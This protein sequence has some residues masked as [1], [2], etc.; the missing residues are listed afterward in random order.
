MIHIWLP[1]RGALAL[2]DENGKQ[3]LWIRSPIKTV[4]RPNEHYL[5]KAWSLVG[6]QEE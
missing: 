6:R 3:T 2:L 4:W 5:D 1:E